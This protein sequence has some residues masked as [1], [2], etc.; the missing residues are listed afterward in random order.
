MEKVIACD[1]DG[2]ITEEDVC[3]KIMEAF[4]DVDWRSIGEEYIRGE[5]PHAEMNARFVQ[6]VKAT[7]VQLDDFLLTRIKLRAG[8]HRFLERCTEKHTRLIILSGGWDYYIRKILGIVNLSFKSSLQELMRSVSNDI[9]VVCNHIDYRVD[10][11][12][13]IES[14]FPAR[15]E[16]CTPDKRAIV[17]AIKG[18]GC[19]NLTVI[20][21]GFTD[22]GMALVADRVFARKS[23]I[24]FC[25][26]QHISFKP[27]E[28]FDDIPS[29]LF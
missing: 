25:R 4:S 27:F 23:L 7:P 2:T 17:T 6:S 12:W 14:Q 8:F 3:D 1:F 18:L 5:I 28:N 10:R 26:D 9:A 15:S 29:E 11:G 20:G 24:K 22:Q 21:D 16:E 19:P 13:S